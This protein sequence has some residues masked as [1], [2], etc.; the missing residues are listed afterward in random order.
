MEHD[1]FLNKSQWE[2][3]IMPVYGAL[4]HDI[5]TDV[6]VVGG[7]ITG[8]LSAYQLAKAGKK[9]VVIEKNSIGGGATRLTTAFLTEYIDTSARDLITM[10]GEE[11]ARSVI[12]S[13]REAISRMEQLIHG[14]E[15]EADFKRIPGF[16]YA[17]NG[18]EQKEVEA[19]R[20]ALLSLGTMAGAVT[21]HLP[22]RATGAIELGNQA[23]FHPLKFIKG[24]LSSIHGYDGQIFAGTEV[25][26]ITHEEKAVHIQTPHGT[27]SAEWVIV[28]TYEP[29]TK[30][31]SLFFKKAFYT[32]YVV[33]LEIPRNAIPEGIYEDTLDPYHYFRIDTGV[34][35]DRMLIGGE[36]H[37]SDLPGID[38][39]TQFAAVRDYAYH[40]LGSIPHKL[41]SH[42]S[43]PILEPVDGLA[44]IGALRDPRVLYA[45]AFSGNGMTYGAIAA[46][47]FH[48]TIVG[49]PNPY[50]ELYR[51]DRAPEL[52]SLGIKARDFTRE[53]FNSAAKNK[54]RRQT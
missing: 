46:Q 9:V 16:I 36:D 42:W 20:E 1:A 18:A 22:F 30:P 10:L 6:V 39:H 27:V 23:K 26:K 4:D 5:H 3:E 35:H 29:F 8:L 14:E 54:L 33:E 34:D 52:L 53:F 37:R 19:E 17:H 44:Y 45:M 49:H 41:I 31:L 24:I 11:N 12:T 38:P 28:A 21:N 15:I 25:T 40:I 50:K 7:G 43:G 13:H 48:D 2:T 32:S 51:A 47:I